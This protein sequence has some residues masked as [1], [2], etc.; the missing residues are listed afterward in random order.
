MPANVINLSL[1]V[2][3]PITLLIFALDVQAAPKEPRQIDSPSQKEMISSSVVQRNEGKI[4]DEKYTALIVDDNGA[5]DLVLLKGSGRNATQISKME[6]VG[7]P[8]TY[9]VKIANNSFYLRTDSAHHGIYYATYQFKIIAKKF[10]LVGVETQSITSCAYSVDPDES[11]TTPCR[12]LDMWAG[13]S[14]N[15]LTSK[16]ECWLQTFTL[17][18]DNQSIDWNKWLA[19]MEYFKQGRRSKHAISRA[20]KIHHSDLVAIDQFDLYNFNIPNTC[21]FDYKGGFH[22]P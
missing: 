7:D 18:K 16:A 14:V 17:D 15:F 20:I 3:L 19:A 2:A 10:Y 22:E 4:D 8:H 9:R 1:K 21:Y 5:P 12:F 6:F 13:T 11:E